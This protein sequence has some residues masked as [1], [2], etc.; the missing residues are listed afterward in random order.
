AMHVSTKDTENK[1]KET[2]QEFKKYF[3]EIEMVHIQSPYSSI[4][5]STIQYVDEVA[6]QAE[7]DNATL[8]VM[9]PQ[10]VPKK[11][12]QTILHNQM[13]L[14]LKYYLKWRENIVISS[15]SYHLKD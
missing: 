8:T 9:I 13:S 12:W 6:T 2:E 7:K 15:Y 1:D 5:Q 3:P 14:R 4:T 11:S 10:F